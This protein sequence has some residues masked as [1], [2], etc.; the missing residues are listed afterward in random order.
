MS[1]HQSQMW[2]LYRFHGHTVMVI[3]QWHDPFGC[4][5]VRIAVVDGIEDI[6]EGMAED[7]FMKEA[8]ASNLETRADG[9][10]SL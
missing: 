10:A 1:T 5:M 6:A 4:A 9:V 8:T 7:R 2:G 3:Q